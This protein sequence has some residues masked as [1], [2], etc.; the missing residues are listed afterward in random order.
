M[1]T[2]NLSR[3]A[4][5]LVQECRLLEKKY[6]LKILTYA[7]TLMLS[8]E[9]PV[10]RYQPVCISVPVSSPRQSCSVSP[11]TEC[12]IIETAAV[13]EICAVEPARPVAV[14]ICNYEV[15]MTYKA[16]GYRIYIYLMRQ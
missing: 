6:I 12:D 5:V 1:K 10:V 15:T 9:V 16:S 7:K 11:R 14:N 4:N 3:C 8:P 2:L 13:E